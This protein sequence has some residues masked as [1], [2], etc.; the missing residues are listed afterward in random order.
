MRVCAHAC[1][2]VHAHILVHLFTSATFYWIRYKHVS[3]KILCVWFP[4]LCSYAYSDEETDMWPV[5]LRELLSLLLGSTLISM[6]NGENR[7]NFK[8]GDVNGADTEVLNYLNV[9]QLLRNLFIRMLIFNT[10]K[11]SHDSLSLTQ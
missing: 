2:H 10:S 1:V 6:E 5:V 9:Q 7:I 11:V 8:K 4:A 3:T